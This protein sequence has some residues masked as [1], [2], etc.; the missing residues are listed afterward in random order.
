MNTQPPPIDNWISI[1]N[2]YIDKQYNNLGIFAS[3]QKDHILSQRLKEQR[4]GQSN[5]RANDSL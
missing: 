2:T 4:D 3:T 5:I 1:G